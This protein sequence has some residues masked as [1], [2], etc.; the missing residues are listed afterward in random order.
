AQ[1]LR[2][3]E[4]FNKNPRAT[5]LRDIAARMRQQLSQGPLPLTFLGQLSLRE[6]HTAAPLQG[7]PSDGTLVFFYDPS[8]NCGYDPEARG[9]CRVLYIP[10][11]EE[12]VPV[13]APASLPDEVK[14]PTRGLRFT[15]EW[16]LPPRL[17]F[18]GGDLSI[19][20]DEDYGT[21]LRQLMSA[22]SEREPVHRCG[23]HP[24]EIQGDMRLECQLVTNGLYCGDPSGYKDPRRAALESGAADWQLL[25]QIDS[26]EERLGWMWSDTGRVYFWI[27]RQDLASTDFDAAWAVLQCY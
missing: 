2:L 20:G 16:T 24:Q 7:W 13:A 27:R 5:G 9:H 3:E 15:Q 17:A 14:F 21:L 4:N 10:E 22:S 8:Q 11:H 19:W 26:D 1:I 23:G 25:L 12:L 18:D 6:L